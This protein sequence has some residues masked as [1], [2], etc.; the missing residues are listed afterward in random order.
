[1]DV[2][3]RED[4]E[5]EGRVA[6]ISGGS[7]GLGRALARRYA[8]EGAAVSLCARGE[9]DL[10]RVAG[11]IRSAG[12]RCLA[13]PADVSSSDD[14]SR[15]FQATAATFGRVD[16]VVNNASV[17]GP[18]VP[19]EDYPEETWRKVTEVNL[20]GAYLCAREAAPRLR[21]SGGS[22]IHVSSGVGDHGRP[23]WGAYCV[24]KNGV[25]ALGEMLAGE[26]EDD[27]ARSNVVDP[28]AM[29]T[30]MR[31]EAYPEEDPESVPRPY[32]VTDVFVYLASDRS[33]DVSGER[34]RA[35]AFEDPDA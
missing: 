28:G 27:G 10:A 33:A 21:E 5:L 24:T 4:G 8:E 13:V 16:V 6:M 11:A 30:E 22:I 7:R 14:V 26:L 32:D 35:L 34:F 25:E 18:L 31:A 29:R 17:L 3:M 2:T 9:D 12:G 19:V 1:M 15:W 20:T 23:E